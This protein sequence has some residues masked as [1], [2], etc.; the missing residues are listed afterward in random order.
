MNH[1]TDLDTDVEYLNIE[2]GAKWPNNKEK[3]YLT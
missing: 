3:R 2:D 1:F